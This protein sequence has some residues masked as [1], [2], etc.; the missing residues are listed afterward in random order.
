MTALMT[1]ISEMRETMH[2]VAWSYERVVAH[3]M[4]SLYSDTEMGIPAKGTEL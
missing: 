3:G 1:E 2:K 4:P